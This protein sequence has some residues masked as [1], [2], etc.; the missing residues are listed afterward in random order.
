MNWAPTRASRQ[1]NYSATVTFIGEGSDISDRYYCS[2]YGRY[3]AVLAAIRLCRLQAIV[4]PS[5]Y[6]WGY[7]SVSTERT[8]HSCQRAGNC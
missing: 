6:V 1:T 7:K 4:W 2:S 5:V 3:A 8:E